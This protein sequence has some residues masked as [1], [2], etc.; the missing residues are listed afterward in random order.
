MEMRRLQRLQY[1]Q[2][3]RILQKQL[4]TEL[5]LRLMLSFLLYKLSYF[6]IQRFKRTKSH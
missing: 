2:M 1:I 5:E 6:Q 4:I 3:K